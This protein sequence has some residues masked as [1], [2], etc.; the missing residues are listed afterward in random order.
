MLFKLYNIIVFCII[1]RFL[2]IVFLS[3]YH[4]YKD[5]REI[6]PSDKNHNPV[7]LARLGSC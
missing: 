2:T 4:P 7:V 1:D 3:K 5:I 6:D